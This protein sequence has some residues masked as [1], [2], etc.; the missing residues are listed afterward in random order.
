[1][2]ALTILAGYKKGFLKNGA[3]YISLVFAILATALMG[4][5]LENVLRDFAVSTLHITSSIG[6]FIT[7]WVIKGLTFAIIFKLCNIL[8]NHLLQTDVKT[9]PD[10]ICGAIFG[11]LQTT[12]LIWL[13]NTLLV[14]VN[15]F[16]GANSVLSSSWLYNTIC[17]VNPIPY[18]F[19]LQTL[20]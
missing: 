12:I 9:L 10:K 19:N 8:I 16:A 14:R 6:L 13:L 3:Y 11:A 4:T 1:M 7:S 17:S 15:I 18:V 2:Y 20:F 5:F